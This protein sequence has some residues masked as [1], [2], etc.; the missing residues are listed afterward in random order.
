MATQ[1][2]WLLYKTTEGTILVFFQ[3]ILIEETFPSVQEKKVMLLQNWKPNPEGERFSAFLF[4]F[5]HVSFHK[6]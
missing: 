1:H 3:E 4:L 6:C 5:F 2:F